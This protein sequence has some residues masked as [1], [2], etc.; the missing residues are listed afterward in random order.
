[1]AEDPTYIFRNGQGTIRVIRGRGC[2]DSFRAAVDR[3]YEGPTRLPNQIGIGILNVSISKIFDVP[4]LNTLIV[5]CK[6]FSCFWGG[7]MY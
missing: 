2:N 6:F 7:R 3:S 1:M 4:R 5:G